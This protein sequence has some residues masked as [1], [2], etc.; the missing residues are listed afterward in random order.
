MLASGPK[1]YNVIVTFLRNLFEKEIH[2]NRIN[3]SLFA[4]TYLMVAILFLPKSL[5]LLSVQL[6]FLVP[7][8][9]NKDVFNCNKS[10]YLIGRIFLFEF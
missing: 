2:H 3:S 5:F 8:K 6:L 10:F 7:S 9:Q 1:I 4:V